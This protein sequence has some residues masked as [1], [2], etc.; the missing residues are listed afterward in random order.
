MQGHAQGALSN[1]DHSPSLTVLNNIGPKSSLAMVPY[2][3]DRFSGRESQQVLS[4]LHKDL[5]RAR[6]R[7]RYI[8]GVARKGQL[9]ARTINAQGLV[10][11]KGLKRG[12]D[13]CSPGPSPLRLW[14]CWAPGR[15][16]FA[17]PKECYLAVFRHQEHELQIQ[18]DPLLRRHGRRV[19]KP[20]VRGLRIKEAFPWT[21]WPRCWWISPIAGPLTRRTSLIATQ[22]DRG[23]RGVGGRHQN[24]PSPAVLGPTSA[25]SRH[26]RG[27]LRSLRCAC[28]HPLGGERPG[29]RGCR[30][31]KCSPQ[32][33]HRVFGRCARRVQS[34]LRPK[35]ATIHLERSFG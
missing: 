26:G 33:R 19:I 11:V 9:A 6:A 28:M 30:A 21:P 12:F 4:V 31:Q 14:R 3:A 1:F 29:R 16:V 18:V 13:C 22:G 17:G 35:K 23:R 25:Q 24:G 27:A 10:S 7:A 32:H 2:V 8:P 15:S 34:A 20:I 5:K